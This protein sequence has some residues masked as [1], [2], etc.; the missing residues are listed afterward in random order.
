MPTPLYTPAR[1][2]PAF[3]L[4][5]SLALFANSPL[6]NSDVWLPA[7]KNAVAADGV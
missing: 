4:R 5:W 7:L 6:P 1:C 3:Q 2:V